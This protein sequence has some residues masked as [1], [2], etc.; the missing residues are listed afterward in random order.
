[1]VLQLLRIKHEIMKWLTF[2]LIKAQL[3]L[4]DEQAELERALLELYGEAAE[5]TILAMTNRTEASLRTVGGGN[6]PSRA[7]QASLLLVDLSYK[8]RSPASP[9]NMSMVPYS[10][11]LLL[12][13]LM[14]LTTGDDDSDDGDIPAGALYDCDGV[15][16]C[17]SE[18]TVLCG[19]A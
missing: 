3:R 14:R 13:R 17:D 5:E 8:E 16:L 7:V 11:D 2:E 4:D 18:G 12:M 9:Q 1:M 10:F 15:L 6:I 19:A